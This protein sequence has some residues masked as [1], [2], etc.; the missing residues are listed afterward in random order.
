MAGEGR[1]RVRKGERRGGGGGGGVWC[2]VVWCGV[3]CVYVWG[4]YVS[5]S[6][7]SSERVAPENTSLVYV[8]PCVHVQRTATPLEL[9]AK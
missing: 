8:W 7:R 1:A 6:L 9:T 2:G 4:V 3:V 5:I